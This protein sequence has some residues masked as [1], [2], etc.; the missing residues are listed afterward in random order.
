MTPESSAVLTTCATC[1]DPI[2][3]S[4]GL[5]VLT[6]TDVTTGGPLGISIVRSYRNLAQP[7]TV[8]PPPFGLGGSHNYAYRLNT[9]SPASSAVIDLIMPDGSRFSFG[10]Q[11][12][13]WVNTTIPALRGAV[14]VAAQNDIDLHWKD[15]TT[16][17]FQPSTFQV[18]S[19]LTSI[20]DV[21]GNTTSIL[22]ESSSHPE[23]ITR[24]IDPVGRS[25]VF[26][27]ESHGY[28]SAIT[29]PLGSHYRLWLLDA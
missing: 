26:G 29:D 5:A 21:N 8:V 4:S 2:D 10:K 1:G 14:M 27:Y 22:H 9:N 24:I 16:F 11:G 15:G 25:L 20:R 18:G 23:R 17:H 6:E 13:T 28:I 7:T 12:N 3:L 19:I